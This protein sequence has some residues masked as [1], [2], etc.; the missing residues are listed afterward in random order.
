M[1]DFLKS[2]FLKREKFSLGAAVLTA[3][4]LLSY[5]TGLLRDRIFAR[6]FGAGRELDLYNASFEIPDLILNV[7]VSSALSAAFIPIF[8]SLIGTDEKEKANKL[9]NTVLH[10]AVAVIFVFGVIAAIG[11]PLILKITKPG[12]TG[13]EHDKLVDLSRLMLISPL[14]MAVSS[15]LGA[16]LVSYKRFLPYGISPILYNL[17]II[18]GT[19]TTAY[20]GVYGLV[21]GTL[22]GAALHLA[23]RLA[24]IKSTPFRYRF[25]VALKDANFIR[26][27]KLTIPKLIGHPIEQINFMAF[28]SIASML[29]AGSITAVSF[30]RNFQSVAVSIFGIAFSVAIYPTLAECVGK[31]DMENFKKNLFKTARSILFFAIP[32]AIGLSLLSYLPIKIFLGGGK[33][34]QENILLTAGLLSV[35]ALSIPFES[36]N[37]LLARAFYS[38]KNTIIPVLCSLTGLIVSVCVAFFGAKT[39]GLIAIP[40]GFLSGQFTKT[41]ALSVILYFRLRRK[42]IAV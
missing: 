16:M 28:S 5:I 39:F 26:V 21:L 35:F 12:F 25:S 30:S 8:S 22:L 4:T 23:P 42:T 36:L 17:G 19:F 32:S 24:V 20:F 40:Y 41:A 9:A 18:C 3:T 31:G 11:M 6:T 2:I 37:S 13:L 33:F 27:I 29:A 1:A 34:T 14:I 7:L 10:S 38:L 15:S